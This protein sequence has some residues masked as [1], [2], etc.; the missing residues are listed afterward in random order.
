MFQGGA[1]IPGGKK[2]GKKVRAGS[3]REPGAT[4]WI[5][6]GG[7]ERPGWKLYWNNVSTGSFFKKTGILSGWG[8]G[9]KKG[10]GAEVPHLF[11]GRCMNPRGKRGVPFVAGGKGEV[12]GAWERGK[13]KKN[14]AGE[15]KKTFDGGAL[16]GFPGN[17]TF[18]TRRPS[19]WERKK[20]TPN[21]GERDHPGDR[22]SR[23][24]FFSNGGGGTG[25]GPRAQ[26]I[27]SWR[28]IKAKGFI[29]RIFWGLPAHS[30]GPA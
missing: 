19:R 26:T 18:S 24:G 27:S 4:W 3:R 29:P 5:L 8:Q 14:K 11:V 10:E 22:K 20:G 2:K 9:K 15:K 12:K 28:A 1:T 13:G 16:K 21:G 17:L 6:A 7:G 25:G 30:S 23:F